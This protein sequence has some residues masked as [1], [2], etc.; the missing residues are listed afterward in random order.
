MIELYAANVTIDSNHNCNGNGSFCSRYGYG[1]EGK[2]I[3]FMPCG[4]EQTIEHGKI[5]IG[6]IEHE[7]NRDKHRQCTTSCNKPLF[8]YKKHYGRKNEKIFQVYHFNPPYYLLRAIT[9]PPT[10]HAKSKILTASK[11]NT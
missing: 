3:A 10:M 5:N 9:N 4:I 8:T 11:G 7:H 1:E 6:S 2:E